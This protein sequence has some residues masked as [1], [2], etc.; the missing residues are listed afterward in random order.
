MHKRNDGEKE[1]GYSQNQLKVR[2]PQSL[3]VNFIRNKV[4]KE[5]LGSCKKAGKLFAGRM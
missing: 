2:I 1:Y 5:F 4:S 3:C